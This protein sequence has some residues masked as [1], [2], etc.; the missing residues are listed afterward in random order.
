MT[1]AAGDTLDF[2]VGRGTNAT[3]SGAAPFLNATISFISVASPT[4]PSIT[5]QPQ[6]QSVNFG[7][8][9]TL[10]VTAIGSSPF[11]YQWYAGASGDLNNPIPGATNAA[12]SPGGV[13]ASESFWVAVQNLEGSADSA[14][15][16]LTPVNPTPP[17]I[18]VQPQSQL[19]ALGQVANLSVTVSGTSPF[20]YQWYAGASGSLI[21][22]I[23]GAT[24]AIFS[25]GGVFASESFWVAVQ[26]SQGGV[27]SSTAVLTVFSESQPALGCGIKAGLPFLTITGLQ[28]ITY[29]I[30]SSTNLATTNWTTLTQVTL[31]GSTFTF[32]DSGATNSARYYRAVTP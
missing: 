1:L 7:Q 13:F 26:N 9:A 4:P 20:T 32:S 24:N 14:T 29:R 8:T 6:S 17:V 12:F 30:R 21:N 18:T 10:S 19:V 11:T 23:P 16:V 5:A 2:L 31:P 22:L 15:A 27:N 3:G 28:R 25:P